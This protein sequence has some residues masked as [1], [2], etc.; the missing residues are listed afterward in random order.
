MKIRQGF[1][2][3]SS[4]S[5]FIC[6][7]TNEIFTGYDCGLEEHGL[8]QCK[9]GHI[10]QESLVLNE[11]E[12][13]KYKDELYENNNKDDEDED[14]D[15]D[16]D[17]FGYETNNPIDTCFCPI[18]SLTHI[19]DS[20]ILNYVLFKHNL[21]KESLIKEIQIDYKTLDDLYT[22]IAEEETEED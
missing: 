3:N 17:Y 5:S 4:S 14:E 7:I 1:V 12:Y 13:E 15:E 8:V 19:S 22:V 6:Q 10:F 20:T 21:D 16:E 18:C 11:K 2:S 9:K